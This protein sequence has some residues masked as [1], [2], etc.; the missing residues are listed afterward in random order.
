MRKIKYVLGLLSMIV[1]FSVNAIYVAAEEPRRIIFY[2]GTEG[3][4]ESQLTRITFTYHYYD[5]SYDYTEVY[6]CKGRVLASPDGYDEPQDRNGDHYRFSHWE[7]VKDGQR[8]RVT[9]DTVFYGDTDLYPVGTNLIDPDYSKVLE[10]IKKQQEEMET[11]KQICIGMLSY[12]PKIQSIKPKK[13]KAIV[14]AMASYEQ[15][16]GYELEYSTSKQFKKTHR[17]KISSTRS[18]LKYTIKKLKKGTTYYVRVRAYALYDLAKYTGNKD[19][20]PR[21]YY[22]KWSKIKKVTITR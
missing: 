2:E 18:S 19:D 22:S 11:A 21:T 7:Y 17:K 16:D 5:G 14:K 10:N 20:R 3:V 1:L 9:E 4:D 12:Q 8:V 15:V 13:K 6:L